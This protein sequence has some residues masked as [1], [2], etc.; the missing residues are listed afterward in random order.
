MKLDPYLLSFP[1]LNPES[2]KDHSIRSDPVTLLEEKVM[3]A[4]PHRSIANDFRK[5]TLI[6]Q[7]V[8]LGKLQ[9]FCTGNGELSKE[10]AH[11]KEEYLW[12]LYIQPRISNMN[13]ERIQKIK[14]QKKQINIEIGY[15]PDQKTLKGRYING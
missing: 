12:Q 15:R 4:L 10:S 9:S 6:A 13:M 1:K 7:E 8:I 3:S 5:R 2:I 11:R 14:H